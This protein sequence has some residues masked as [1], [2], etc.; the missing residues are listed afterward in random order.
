MV[1]AN[2]SNKIEPIL[3]GSTLGVIGG[4]QLGRMFAEAAKKLGYRVHVLADKPNSPCGQVADFELVASYNDATAFKQLAKDCAVVTYEFENI[5]SSALTD[6]LDICPVRPSPQ[7][8]RI[9][10]HRLREKTFLRDHGI[11]VAPFVR[12]NNSTELRAAVEKLGRPAVL[13]TADFGYDGKGQFK[14]TS[15]TKLSELDEIFDGREFV[16]EGFI[17]FLKEVSV[18][19]ARS[20]SGEIVTWPVF[21]NTHANHILDVTFAPALIS[22][23]LAASARAIATSV[24]D[25][26]ELVGV[27]CVE[28]FVVDDLGILVNEIA[29]R[30][31]NSGHLTIE[32][33]E[34]SQFEQQVRAICGLPLGPT[35]LKSPAAMAN[36]LGDLWEAREPRWDAL[37]KDGSLKLHLY[38]KPNPMPGKKMGHL[39]SLAR[40]TEE[41]VGVVTKARSGL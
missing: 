36:L 27:A 23:E 28:M 1:A 30:P 14:I 29:P 11:P 17:N 6:L 21:E 31:H 32:A 22:D 4:G 39:T 9:A 2:T 13:K 37:P 5:E 12:V 38:G 10:Q 41:A 24:F 16:L 8:I 15:E 34:T 19:G 20:L 40:T 25:K 7:V 3:P 33:S 18:V 26:L 35:A